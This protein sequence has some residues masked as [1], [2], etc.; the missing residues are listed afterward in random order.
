MQG[1]MVKW[2]LVFFSIP[3]VWGLRG[4][5]RNTAFCLNKA[6]VLSTGSEGAGSWWGGGEPTMAFFHPRFWSLASWVCVRKAPGRHHESSVG[7]RV[8]PEAK[9]I[10][11]FNLTRLLNFI[12]EI[13]F[14]KYLKIFNRY[15]LC[16][17]QEGTRHL[18]TAEKWS[19]LLLNSQSGRET[20][21]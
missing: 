9:I 8:T 11:H 1:I 16:A 4:Q 17:R 14:F 12:L 18:E 5:K 21:I 7:G 2:A 3:G 13:H 6:S 10:G 19:P 20:W 15:L